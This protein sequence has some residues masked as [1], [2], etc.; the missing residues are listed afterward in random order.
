M[1]R[2]MTHHLRGKMPEPEK[3]T[4]RTGSAPPKGLSFARSNRP[5]RTVHLTR[6]GH[7]ALCK[8]ALCIYSTSRHP[9]R[10]GDILCVR[11]A[12]VAAGVAGS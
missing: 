3:F 12:K 7:A 11:C 1:S 8:A 6:L 9:V 2:Q 10:D 4:L 5:G